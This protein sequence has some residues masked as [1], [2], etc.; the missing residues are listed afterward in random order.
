MVKRIKIVCLILVIVSLLSLKAQPV[1]ASFISWLFS[2]VNDA[3]L[4]VSKPEVKPEVIKEPEIIREPIIKTIVKEVPIIKAV[5]VIREVVIERAVVQEIPIDRIVYQDNPQQEQVI[6]NL[7][8]QVS[9]FYDYILR[10]EKQLREQQPNTIIKEVIREIEVPVDRIVYQ[11]STCPICLACSE[12]QIPEPEPESPIYESSLSV[13][14]I[15]TGGD[16]DISNPPPTISIMELQLRAGKENLANV[17]SIAFTI[18]NNCP[19]DN[20]TEVPQVAY[21]YS[22]VSGDL[23]FELV[24]TSPVLFTNQV[25]DGYIFFENLLDKIM[26]PADMS[27]SVR[28]WIDTPVCEKPAKLFSIILYPSGNPYRNPSGIKWSDG[29]DNFEVVQGKE[30]KGIIGF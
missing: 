26:I 15:G 2:K 23:L 19:T 27:R 13:W 30:I 14:G 9:E 29:V 5:E 21:L 20:L 11:Q 8:E 4:F 16:I 12:P 6:K 1:Q 25:Q 3:I 10:L 22:K 18:S 17:Q 28:L 24:A 7:R